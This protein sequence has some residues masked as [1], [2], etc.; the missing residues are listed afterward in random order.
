MAFGDTEIPMAAKDL[1]KAK[2]NV[3]QVP[4]DLGGVAISYNVPGAPKGLRLDGS[5]LAA[6]FEGVITN[7]DSPALATLTGVNNLPNRRS[8]RCTGPIPRARVGTSTSTSSELVQLGIEDRHSD[9]S[10]T[11]PLPKR[12]GGR[13]AQ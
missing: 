3:L 5:T 7:W 8:C 10:K 4:V 13:A 12:G 11:W 1:A 9:P 2:G 6:I